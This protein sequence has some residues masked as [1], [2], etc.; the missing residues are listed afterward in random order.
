MFEKASRQKLR[1]NTSRG[2]LTVE[3][4]WD[5]PLTSATGKPNLDDIA[6]NLNRQIRDSGVETSFV[7]PSASGVDAETQLGFEIVKHVIAVRIA[8]RDAA[9]AAAKKRE[10]KAKILQIIASKQDEA[11][12]SKSLEEL[13]ALAE[14]M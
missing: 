1:F 8:E 6:R 2:L 11:L 4:L 14:S 12:Q 9:S 10:T 5:L 13:Q 3:D 7:D